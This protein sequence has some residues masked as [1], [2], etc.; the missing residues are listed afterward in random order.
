MA[1][2]LVAGALAMAAVP[3]A[4]A[5][6]DSA[7]CRDSGAAQICQRQGHT[8]LR[9]SPVVPNRWD[10]CSGRRGC[11]IRRGQLP[12]L[13]ALDP[14]LRF[15]GAPGSRGPHRAGRPGSVRADRVMVDE[16]G[17]RYFYVT[18]LLKVLGAGSFHHLMGIRDGDGALWPAKGHL[19][20][21]G[22]RRHPGNRFLVGDRLQHKKQRV[23]PGCPGRSD[24]FGYQDAR[25][26]PAQVCKTLDP[27]PGLDRFRN[28]WDFTGFIGLVRL[29]GLAGLSDS[30]G[31][32]GCPDSAD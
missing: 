21:H 22:L 28:G 26:P 20:A 18:Y 4:H 10:R 14:R 24:R 30:L 32:S 23:R 1:P 29:I 11:R 9:T 17:Q 2:L 12:P 13:I 27:R 6:S 19:Q 7:T 25:S 8:S 15:P 3:T 5:S 16:R 31:S